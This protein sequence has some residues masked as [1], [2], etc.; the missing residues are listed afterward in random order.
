MSSDMQIAT[1]MAKRK[2]Q[3]SEKAPNKKKL[4]FSLLPLS[5]ICVCMQYMLYQT[6]SVSS[7]CFL[8]I[9]VVFLL[10]RGRI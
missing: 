10:S 1:E 8:R 4:V 6:V 7:I 3:E 5:H 9:K 2:T